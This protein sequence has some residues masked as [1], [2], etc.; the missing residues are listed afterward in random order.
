LLF[1][2]ITTAAYLVI[3][4]LFLPVLLSEG[5]VSNPAVYL[6]FY[7]IVSVQIIET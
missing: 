7:L 6:P 2:L 5:G 3:V 4:P 1:S